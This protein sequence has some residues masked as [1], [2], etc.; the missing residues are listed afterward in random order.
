LLKVALKIVAL[1]NLKR[2]IRP[3]F[4]EE[5]VTYVGAELVAVLIQERIRPRTN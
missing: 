5:R 1:T 3:V 4:P 2:A